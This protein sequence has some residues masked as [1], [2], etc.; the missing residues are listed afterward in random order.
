MRDMRKRDEREGKEWERA[1]GERDRQRLP[2]VM[3]RLN[4]ISL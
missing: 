1:T 2:E 3:R 4:S